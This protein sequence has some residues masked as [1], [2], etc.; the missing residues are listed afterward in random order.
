M[1]ELESIGKTYGDGD[2]TTTVLEGVTFRIE[3]GEYVSIMGTSGAGKST[4]MHILGCLDRPTDGSYRFNGTEVGELEDRPLSRLRNEK[5]GFV[6]QQFHLLDRATALRNVMLPLVYA[7]EYPRD[8]EERA[9]SALVAVGLED[10]MKYRPGELSGGQQQRVAIAR[11]LVNDPQLIL[12]DEP[13]GNLDRRS[14]LEI[15]GIFKRLHRE[16]RTIVVVTHDDAVANHTDRILVLEAGRIASDGAVPSPRN[17]EGEIEKLE[18][19]APGNDAV[20]AEED[21]R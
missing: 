2:M 11:A 9:E 4:L 1:I 15:L 21:G 14:S 18:E 7:R 16:G 5:I 12:A 20:P 3:A 19:E 8:A 13:T 10:R 6:F 17:A